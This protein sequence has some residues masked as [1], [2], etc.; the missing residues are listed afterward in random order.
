MRLQVHAKGVML[1][2]ALHMGR[3]LVL[4]KA[5]GSAVQRA[6]KAPMEP[7]ANKPAVSAPEH[8]APASSAHFCPVPSSR[9][10]LPING[11]SGSSNGGSSSEQTGSGAC[12]RGERLSPN[13]GCGLP[14]GA[15]FE[16]AAAGRGEITAGRAEAAGA[17]LS[18]GRLLEMREQT[19]P[20]IEVL[21]AGRRTFGE[22]RDI[23][24]GISRLYL[25]AA[26]AFGC[27]MLCLGV[28][29]VLQTELQWHPSAS[30]IQLRSIQR[31]PSTQMAA[32]QISHAISLLD[33]H[34]RPP[35]ARGALR[36]WP[37]TRADDAVAG[38][39]EPNVLK[40]GTNAGERWLPGPSGSLRGVNRSRE[41]TGVGDKSEYAICHAQ[42][43]GLTPVDYSV[44]SLAAYFKPNELPR[45]M[46][47]LFPAD[48]HNVAPVV[49]PFAPRPAGDGSANGD[50]QA[51]PDAGAVSEGNVFW[52]EFR[53]D[54]KNLTVIALRGTEFWNFC[55]WL[56]DIRMWTGIR[57]YRDRVP[58]C[59]CMCECRLL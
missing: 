19:N 9:S 37:W 57:K 55:D 50:A 32:T 27:T 8:R 4:H 45:I 1:A 11:G 46:P 54:D 42:F 15:S 35:A 24:A 49:V 41:G 59:A 10:T 48:E 58:C 34:H 16:A 36:Q 2:V 43:W 29:S 3:A 44:L 20:A 26:A 5:K 30:F 7:H 31:H 52:T 53:F 23:A 33:L 47:I 38:S 22:S 14:R 18:S 25:T 51:R 28:V 56:E 40:A 17:Y 12:G 6:E 21:R 39:G 13:T